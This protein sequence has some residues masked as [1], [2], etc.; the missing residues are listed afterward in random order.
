[1]S[2]QFDQAEH[3]SA[4]YIERMD[5]FRKADT[6]DLATALA[7]SLASGSGRAHLLLLAL[8]A[9][10]AVTDLVSFRIPNALT[11]GGMVAGVIAGTLHAPVAWGGFAGALGG[12]LTGLLV[13][14]PLHLMRLLGAGDV[15]LVAAVGAFLGVA[16]L[17]AAL[18]FIFVAAGLVALGA[19]ALRCTGGPGR[20]GLLAGRIP[21]AVA[22][23]AGTAVFLFA[24]H[25]SGG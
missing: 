19:I 13:L 9:A 2:G 1:M 23:L 16:D 4:S 14:L 25:G 6:V 22:I 15:K 11:V 3:A 12:L 21:Y 10:A 5:S 20:G 17:L 24:R 8:L 18:L 7:S